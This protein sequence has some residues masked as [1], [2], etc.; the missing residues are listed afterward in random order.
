LVAGGWRQ[1]CYAIPYAEIYDPATGSWTST[2]AM[3]TPRYMHTATKLSTGKVL[4]TGGGLDGGGNPTFDTTELY[5]PQTG[6][7]SPLPSMMTPRAHHTATY[8]PN[9]KVLIAGGGVWGVDLL[10]SAELYTPDGGSNGL[11]VNIT[12]AGTVTSTPIGIDCGATCSANFTTGLPVVLTAAPAMGSVFAGWSGGCS[13]TGSCSLTMDNDKT[14]TATFNV[15]VPW[16]PTGTLNAKRSGH[17]ATLLSNGTVL[18]AGSLAYSI[19]LGHYVSLASSEI[20]NPLT[21]SWTLSGLM[22]EP[23][24]IHTATL[25]PNGKVLVA[26]GAYSDSAPW[27]V[28]ST[29]ELYDPATGSWSYTGAMNQSRFWHASVLLHNGKVLVMGGADGSDNHLTSAEIYDLETGVWTVTGAMHEPRFSP[30]VS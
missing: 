24:G 10:E 28:R 5:D 15:A 23:R 17:T 4:V 12:G 7:W 8:L 11:T 19:P 30:N 26:G 18:V 21:A 29:A 9:N 14:V 16:T 25:L 3:N 13:G 1:C 2:G 27:I 22:N 6:V 20:Y